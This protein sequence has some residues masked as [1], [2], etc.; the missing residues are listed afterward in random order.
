[1]ERRDPTIAGI[2]KESAERVGRFM[3]E[4]RRRRRLGLCPECGSGG[5]V[6]ERGDNF[7]IARCRGCG[8]HFI[9]PASGGP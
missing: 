4:Y 9:A 5:K 8:F 1:M 7:D 6:I 3:D 2:I